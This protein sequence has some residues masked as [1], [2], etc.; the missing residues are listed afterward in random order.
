MLLAVNRMI[1]RDWTICT[2]EAIGLS[3]VDDEESPW[4]GK[5]PITPVM[6]TQLDQIVIRDVLTPLRQRLLSELQAKMETG[7]KEDWFEVF[8]VVFILSTNTEWLL[9][10]SRNNAKR[11]GAKVRFINL[12]RWW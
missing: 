6:D 4:H 3:T 12:H 11:Y 9:R 5:V 8:L 10:H 7:Q 1:E 2:P